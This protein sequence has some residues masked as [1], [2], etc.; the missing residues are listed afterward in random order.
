M[1]KIILI[2]ILLT[3]KFIAFAQGDPGDNPDAD[4]PLDG[5]VLF[6]AAAGAA[7]AIKKLKGSKTPRSEK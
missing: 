6:M 5:G 1:K 4:V 2:A 7:Y 3:V